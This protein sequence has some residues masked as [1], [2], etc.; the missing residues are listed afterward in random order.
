MS[1]AAQSVG[2]LAP[3]R[4]LAATYGQEAPEAPVARRVRVEAVP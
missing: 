3:G 4:L 2:L 1:G